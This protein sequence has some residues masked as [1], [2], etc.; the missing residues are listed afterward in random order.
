M[1]REKGE[2]T[3]Q[4]TLLVTPETRALADSLA[5]RMSQPGIDVTRTDVL[6]AALLRGLEALA[7]AHP[8]KPRGGRGRG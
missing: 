7:E 3:V 2:N 5:K 1:P 6:R 4:L 8:E